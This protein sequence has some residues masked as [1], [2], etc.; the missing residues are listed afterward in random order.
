MGDVPSLKQKAAKPVSIKPNGI[1]FQSLAKD[2]GYVK[3]RQ[4]LA[5]ANIQSQQAK[6]K[7]VEAD[8]NSSKRPLRLKESITLASTFGNFNSDS[9]LERIMKGNQAILLSESAQV[10]ILEELMSKKRKLVS[11]QTGVDEP[12]K[13]VVVTDRPSTELPPPQGPHQFLPKSDG[14]EYKFTEDDILRHTLESDS[15]T[16]LIANQ[17]KSELPAGLGDTL[18]LQLG[19]CKRLICTRNNLRNIIS[20]EIPQ[21]SMYHLRYLTQI[22]LS[23]NKINQLPSDFGVL[24]QLA[25]LDLSQN[26]LSGLPATFRHLK[27]LAT[28]NLSGNSFAKLPAA[29]AYLDSLETLDLSNNLFT[30]FPCMVLRLRALKNFKF[31]RNSLT[32]LAVPPALL[33]QEDMWT[34]VIDRRT[35]KTVNMNIL[36]NER[37]A[38]IEKYDGSGVRK[39]RDLHVFQPEGTKI[40]R[41][42][43]IWLSVNQIQE[44]EPD[45]DVNTG[46][47]YYR[48]NVSGGTSWSMPASMDTLGD[49]QAL[50]HFEIKMN[51]IKS[52]PD[53][54]VS[55]VNLRKLVFTKNRLNA[56]PDGISNLKSLTHLE[57]TSNELRILPTT[58]CDCEA[59]E[60][61]ILND[62]HLLRLPANLGRLPHLKKLDVSSNHLKQ[63]SHTLGFC[64]TLEA[65]LVLENPLEDPP[66]EEFGK[67]MD[68]VKW[69]LRNRYHIESRGMP[70][71][72]QFHQ[73]GIC[74]QV[75]VLMPEFTAIVRQ[76]IASSKRDGLLNM[77]LLGLKLIPPDVLK[78][79]HLKRLKL[80]F[81]DHLGFEKEGFPLQLS[82]LVTLSVRACRLEYVP[83]NVYIFGRL[84]TL[85]IHEN[86]FESLPDTITELRALTCLGTLCLTVHFS[87]LDGT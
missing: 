7:A 55:M 22:N 86:R 32:H 15:Y 71:P 85:S 36:T 87:I 10:E 65:L 69:Y 56:L 47:V 17:D 64:E 61:L 84:T 42:R 38:N 43:K 12:Q 26:N 4:L 20:H 57:V 78:I 18:N 44:W 5:Q 40:Y 14:E 77:Q 50:E 9:V 34:K 35:G 8:L 53:S 29:F 68:T 83:E 31:N 63:I 16:L 72:M 73:I 48:N 66:M 39:M 82:T 80:D 46:L 45:T 27:K 70:P 54:F 58:I 51:S 11:S 1:D 81:N 75:T 6:I 76:L 21:L 13:V 67:G 33:Q 19:Y 79:P 24:V 28:L 37:I 74:S 62:N 3:A 41:K 60:V 25:T 30:L 2:H 52:L 49:L 23:L 59:L